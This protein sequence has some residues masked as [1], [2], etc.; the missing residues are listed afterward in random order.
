MLLPRVAEDAPQS[1]VLQATILADKKRCFFEYPIPLHAF[2]TVA[3][4]AAVV[5]GPSSICCASISAKLGRMAFCAESD[6][7]EWRAELG[8]SPN[9]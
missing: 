2:G 6:E 4:I 1:A 5:C 7:P 8:I 9:V 3:D